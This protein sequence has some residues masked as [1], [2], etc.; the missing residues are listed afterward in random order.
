MSSRDFE[1]LR[2]TASSGDN[3]KAVSKHW[4]ATSRLSWMTKTFKINSTLASLMW[5]PVHQKTSF[6]TAS[7]QPK[8][9]RWQVLAS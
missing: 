4:T 5:V 8:T 2:E 7:V 1:T 3:S 9:E 6:R